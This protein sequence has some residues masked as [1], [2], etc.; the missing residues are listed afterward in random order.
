MAAVGEATGSWIADVAATMA[1][2]MNRVKDF[3]VDYY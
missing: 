2:Q 3:M 1:A